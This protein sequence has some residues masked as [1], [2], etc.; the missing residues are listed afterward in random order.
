M[1]SSCVDRRFANLSTLVMSLIGDMNHR[2]NKTPVA[3]W[4]R[5]LARSLH[6]RAFTSGGRL[7]LVAGRPQYSRLKKQLA[8]TAVDN[9]NVQTSSLE[10]WG[11]AKCDIAEL[12]V[13]G[14]DSRRRAIEK[15]AEVLQQQ[16]RRAKLKPHRRR[17]VSNELREIDRL[18]TRVNELA[19]RLE[20][21]ACENQGEMLILS[22]QDEAW[23]S[24]V[25]RDERGELSTTMQWQARVVF[26]LAGKKAA[27]RYLQAVA[28]FRRSTKLNDTI[29][30]FKAFRR[31]LYRWIRRA[32]TQSLQSLCDL[33][34]DS[35]RELPQPAAKKA[36]LT[37][38]LRGRSFANHCEMLI[39][40][41]D[42]YLAA[43]CDSAMHYAAATIAAVTASD[44]A[45][46]AIPE[47]MVLTA[48]ETD[49]QNAIDGTLGRLIQNAHQPKYNE[50]LEA[51][52]QLGNSIS[53][54]ECRAIR[55]LLVRNAKPQDIA[56][57]RKMGLL[58]WFGNKQTPIRWLRLF[59]NKLKK[60]GLKLSVSE[61][62]QVAESTDRSHDR[63][64]F[65]RFAGWLMRFSL[66]TFSPRNR[67]LA[68]KALQDLFVPAMRSFG[69][70]D[71]LGRWCKPD[72][73]K[74]GKVDLRDKANMS[75]LR[76][77]STWL[78][79]MGH[80]QQMIGKEPAIPKSVARFTKFADSRMRERDFLRRR[81]A[82]GA[83]TA[84]QAQRLAFLEDPAN[85]AAPVSPAKL[86]RAVEE[87]CLA[88]ACDALRFLVTDEIRNQWQNVADQR[89]PKCS[90]TRSM[91]FATWA[92]KM[93][94]AEAELLREILAAA[95]KYKSGYRW[96]LSKNRDWINNA[97]NN[98]LNWDAWTKSPQLATTVDDRKVVIEVVN[99]PIEVFQM[100]SYFNTCLSL[101]G[102]NQ[103]S[104]LANAHDANKQVLFMRDARGH[105]V[106]RQLVAISTKFELL[107]YHCYS[108]VNHREPEIF[109]K[110]ISAMA[111]Y[112]GS[113]A[114]RCGLKLAS[115]GIPESIGSHFW[116]DDEAHNWHDAAHSVW[117]QAGETTPIIMKAITNGDSP[118]ILA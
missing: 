61:I 4:W 34:R 62:E 37:S 55:K 94:P 45:T 50:M 72:S 60:Q 117:K 80:Y 91:E 110:Y 53:F 82:E 58:E 24:N 9:S 18:R 63:I 48:L 106:A 109:K 57:V 6:Q 86:Q 88:A 84:K 10:H 112:C 56:W 5:D 25:L 21:A 52:P 1:Q 97:K 54:R 11:F 12:G 74:S 38:R 59:V 35:V 31:N 79:L 101:G 66:P 108:A 105:V 67:Q 41:V 69:A 64:A 70:H 118:A 103:M 14:L 28:P 44:N 13:G 111:A 78:E 102:C 87:A 81:I 20:C 51:L 26:W 93:L 115:D 75:I 89:L 76:P 116:Y 96:K 104:V 2:L 17:G 22:W 7:F 47:A 65:D 49:Y 85:Q 98:G 29:E 99:D 30:K 90:F 8:R 83:I 32:T 73:P 114:R 46:A 100:G 33:L 92:V 107:G 40:R 27:T 77:V 42:K 95:R 36:K 39:R 23:L 68:W 19:N 71:K 3:G 43:Q 113:W 15:W 16:Q